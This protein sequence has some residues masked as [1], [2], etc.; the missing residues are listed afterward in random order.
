MSEL[1]SAHGAKTDELLSTKFALLHL[2]S[3]RESLLARLDQGLDHKLTFSL[4]HPAS[5]KRPSSASGSS[6]LDLRILI[7]D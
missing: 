2:R 7:L 6:L 4:P 3:P 5:A 1:Q